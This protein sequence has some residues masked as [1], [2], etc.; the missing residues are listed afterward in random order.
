MSELLKEH[1]RPFDPEHDGK[2]WRLKGIFASTRPNAN[3]RTYPREV[4]EAAI[5][6][7]TEQYLR[8]GTAYGNLDHPGSP[9]QELK[10]AAVLITSL[11]WVGDEVW[12]EATVLDTP[13]GTILQK[14]IEGGGTVGMSTR[15]V[16]VQGKDGTI[17][18][19]TLTGIDVVAHASSPS[20]RKVQAIYE[21]EELQERCCD[22]DE[23]ANN[24]K[25]VAGLDAPPGKRLKRILASINS[26]YARRRNTRDHVVINPPLKDDPDRT[27][28]TSPA[29]R[30]THPQRR[31]RMGM[32]EDFPNTDG[33]KY[34][35]PDSKVP[36]TKGKPKFLRPRGSKKGMLEQVTLDE[37]VVTGMLKAVATHY[38]TKAL[39]STPVGK[40]LYGAAKEMHKAWRSQKPKTA[41]KNTNLPE[42][43]TQCNAAYL[44]ERQQG[45]LST[46]PRRAGPNRRRAACSGDGGSGASTL[47]GPNGT[48]VRHHRSPEWSCSRSRP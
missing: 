35:S 18:N 20:A 26:L 1:I 25:N 48:A 7:Y 3:G 19:Y 5:A 43:P 38:G 29:A 2:A 45:H 40:D 46:R 11:D 16:G 28:G 41:T 39:R 34:L 27:H 6:K 17:S 13:N 37:A 24:T 32:K 47:C 33:K 30:T 15:G 22:E 36:T 42:N 9:S 21:D 44:K 12:G 14:I 4:L 8:N 23:P 10:D 31:N